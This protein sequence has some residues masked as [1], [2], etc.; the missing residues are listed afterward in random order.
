MKTVKNRGTQF[1]GG[2][3]PDLSDLAVYGVLN[4]IEGCS[5]FQDALEH[6]SI[7]TWYYSVKQ[8]VQSHAG[9][10]ALNG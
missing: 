1:L 7:G 2:E 5:A 3:S 4:S 10:S 9:C 8:S 6:T